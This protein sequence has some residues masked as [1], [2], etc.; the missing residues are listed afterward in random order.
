METSHH[1]TRA[2]FVFAC[3]HY[4][5]GG[6]EGIRGCLSLRSAIIHVGMALIN[7]CTPFPHPFNTPFRT[8]ILC[9]AT[10]EGVETQICNG[11]PTPFLVKEGAKEFSVYEG[12]V[13]EAVEG[14][15]YQGMKALAPFIDS[16]F[17]FGGSATDTSGVTDVLKASFPL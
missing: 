2:Y 16:I 3:E 7:G 6:E 12:I 4:L 10:N 15:R 17:V 13:S 1:C 11:L 14:V 8:Q 9:R 5:R